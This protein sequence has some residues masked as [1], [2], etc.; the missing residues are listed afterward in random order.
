VRSAP[1]R[2]LTVFSAQPDNGGNTPPVDIASATHVV[3]HGA[4][5]VLCARLDRPIMT[6]GAPSQEQALQ[7]LGT[8]IRT[9]RKRRRLTQRVLAARVGLTRTYVS[10]IEHGQRNV[11]IWTLLLIAAALQ[12][13]LSTL[14]QPLEAYPELYALPGEE[15]S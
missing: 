15:H 10:A 8:T 6:D 2:T 1:T 9:F 5:G 11:T 4:H 7:L 12:V 14:L 13:P 3:W